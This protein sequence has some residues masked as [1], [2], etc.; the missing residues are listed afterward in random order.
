MPT[1]TALQDAPQQLFAAAERVLLREGPAGLTSRSVTA[2]LGV[3]K[4]VLHRHFPDFDSF[5]AALVR[6]RVAGLSVWADA[7]LGAAGGG[8]VAGNLAAALDSL[9]DPVTR[10]VVTLVVARDDLRRLLRETTPSG[11]PVLV[12]ATETVA[13]YLRAERDL[14]RVRATTDVRAL[15]LTVIGTGHLLYAGELGGLPDDR[16]VDEVV[17]SMLVGAETGEQ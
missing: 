9:F 16:A 5:L 15:A 6:Q 11:I 3:A 12:E 2:E 7:L 10:A 17:A 13:D 1:G 8:S 14:G 4:G